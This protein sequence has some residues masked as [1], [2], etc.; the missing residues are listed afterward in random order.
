MKY[1]TEISIFQVQQHKHKNISTQVEYYT[2]EATNYTVT[3][4]FTMLIA[5]KKIYY[6]RRDSTIRFRY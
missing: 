5:D 6:Y 2:M 4:L 3:I 1:D